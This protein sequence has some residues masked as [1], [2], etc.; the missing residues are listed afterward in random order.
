MAECA[1][2]I[3]SRSNETR[4]TLS[5]APLAMHPLL[6][7]K[8]LALIAVANATPVIAK[9]LLG[10]WFNWPLDAGIRLSDGQPLFGAS[11]TVRGVLLALA[12]TSGCAPLVN[13]RWQGGAIIA[14]A[15]MAGDLCSSF[16][17]RR[18][19]LA[20]AS[21][22]T[23]LDQ[24]PESL[25]PMLAARTALGLSATDIC[26]GVVFFF[27][28]EMFLSRLFYRIGLRDQPY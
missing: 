4:E 19:Y 12:V 22:A 2:S 15:A 9:D 17:K 24:I 7:A 10:G 26:V 5:L 11:K 1:R 23:A 8:V 25:F 18:M 14:S 28:G 16:V 21:K 13:L 6:I 3:S 27:V 20:P